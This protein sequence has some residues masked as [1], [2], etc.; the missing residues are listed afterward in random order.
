[1]KPAALRNKQPYKLSQ[2]KCTNSLPGLGERKA[3]QDPQTGSSDRIAWNRGIKKSHSH[4]SGDSLR[5]CVCVCVCVFVCVCECS[6]DFNGSKR[7]D[8]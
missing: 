6:M 7:L 8:E 2:C 5:W 3:R 1:V 4:E